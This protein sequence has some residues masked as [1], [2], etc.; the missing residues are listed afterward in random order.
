VRYSHAVANWL[1]ARLG[2][3]VALTGDLLEECAGGRSTI[4]YW[5]QVLIA[6]W[7]GIWGAIRE[8][9]LLTLRAIAT[10]FAIE[11]LLIYL[12]QF[13]PDSPLS[14]VDIW[15]V[16]IPTT[17]LAHAATGWIVARTHRA[18]PVPMASAFL[19]CL[20]LWYVSRTFS[21]V[22]TIQVDSLTQ[23]E[24]R[25]YL[26]LYIVTILV[27]I[28][29]ILGGSLLG[30][31]P[32]EPA[33]TPKPE[34]TGI[35]A[36]IGEHKLL[37]LRAIATGFALNFLFIL[38]W[39]TFHLDILLTHTI[40]WLADLLSQAV[41]GWAV[42]RTRRAQPIPT[43]L[44]FMACLLLWKLCLDFS[45][46]KMLLMDSMDQPRF[47]PYL[48]SHFV[49]YLVAIVG[50]LAGGILGARPNERSSALKI[51]KGVA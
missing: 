41:T 15:L 2:L 11:L 12:W 34:L 10:G 16:G 25:P 22:R 23:P 46:V 28:V 48:V 26:A 47:R 42:A 31:R 7:T 17:L 3:D 14:S 29:G 44:A 8:H 40:G 19:V 32:K 43:V 13:T 36:D 9:K 4:W 18:H 24:A 37:A 33:S 5:R 21:A 30:A 51:D 20:L 38:L 35:W 6:M 1:F 39:N 27:T 50:I 49:P 45:M